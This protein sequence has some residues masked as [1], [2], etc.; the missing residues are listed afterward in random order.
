MLLFTTTHL[1]T[2]RQYCSTHY[3][4]NGMTTSKTPVPMRFGLPITTFPD[5]LSTLR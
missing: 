3:C 5:G 2:S 4:G 1:Y